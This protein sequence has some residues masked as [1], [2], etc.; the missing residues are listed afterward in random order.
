MAK[1]FEKYNTKK[2]FLKGLG[3]WYIMPFSTIFQKTIDLPQVTDKVYHV[4]LYTAHLAM[5]GI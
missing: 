2:T 5:S 1:C 4:M 3:L